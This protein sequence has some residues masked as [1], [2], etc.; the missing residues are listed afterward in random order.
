MDTVT[1]DISF[2]SSDLLIY[3]YTH[4]GVN[5][6]CRYFYRKINKVWALGTDFQNYTI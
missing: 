5:G 4:V 1:S 6:T 2:H 3:V